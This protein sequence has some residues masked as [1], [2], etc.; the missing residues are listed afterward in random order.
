MDE[1]KK[2]INSR[3]L[4]IFFIM[5]FLF[6]TLDYLFIISYYSFN[7]TINNTTIT[8]IISIILKYLVLIT[9]FIFQ[10][11]KY[12]KEKWFDFIK[13]IKKYF[14]I[15]FKY[16]FIGFI[17]MIVSNSIINYLFPGLGKNEESVQLLIKKLPLIAFFLT[18]IFAPFVEEM[19]FRKYLQDGI[20]NKTIYAIASGLIFGFIH[21][22]GSNNALEYLLIIPYGALG[23]MFAK[24]INK[25]DNI[26]CTI[27]MH[28]LH[29]GF[30][31]ILSIWVM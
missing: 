29:N 26:Y 18:T 13:N 25:T 9:I 14:E 24:I 11:H 4:I 1:L 3:N 5:L 20:K 23:Y 31:T 27:M 21:V 12:L 22:M 6:L 7:G 30:L 17:I 19:I 16:W 8:S 28:M 15:S 10:Y 2:Y